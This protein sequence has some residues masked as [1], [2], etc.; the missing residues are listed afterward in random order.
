MAFGKDRA[1]LIYQLVVF[2][3][4][5]FRKERFCRIFSGKLTELYFV[6]I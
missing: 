4:F 5:P 6:F 3:G 2:F 1:Q